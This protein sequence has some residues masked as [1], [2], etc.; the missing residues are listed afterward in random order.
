MAVGLSCFMGAI[1]SL[2][3]LK[4]IQINPS[5]LELYPYDFA[6]EAFTISQPF[7]I[8]NSYGLFRRMTGVGGRPE[9]VIRGGGG[10]EGEKWKEYDLWYKPGSNPEV[11]PPIVMPHQPRFDWQ[12]W[13]SALGKVET[14]TFLLHF[15][16][17]ILNND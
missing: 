14:E 6:K 17:K 10:G 3:F 9:I 12:I 16:Y 8:A 13:F 1:T 2:T 5:S 4:G 11:P 7:H 15:V